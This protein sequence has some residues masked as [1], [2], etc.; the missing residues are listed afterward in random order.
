MGSNRGAGSRGS[1]VAAPVL[2]HPPTIPARPP[3]TWLLN[4]YLC[5]STIPRQ[6]EAMDFSHCARVMRLMRA[7]LR[8]PRKPVPTAVND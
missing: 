2:Q 3:P 6:H 7:Q 5:C 4:S 8:G 1:V